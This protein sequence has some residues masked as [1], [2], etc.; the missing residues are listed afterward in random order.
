MSE[1]VSRY[2]QYYREQTPESVVGLFSCMV[3]YDFFSYHDDMKKVYAMWRETRSKGDRSRFCSNGSTTGMPRSLY[4]A[5]NFLL[6]RNS[7]EPF[8]RGKELK[9]MMIAAQ[10]GRP[11]LDPFRHSEVLKNSQKDID[12]V[13]DWLSDKD[14][15]KLFSLVSDM[16]DRYGPI[17]LYALPDIWTCL[18]TNPSFRFLVEENRK[19]VAS[20]VN[21]DYDSIFK[22]IGVHVRDQM[23]D[24]GTG[25]NFFDCEF[26]TRHFL[27]LFFW[28]GLGC[29]N[30]V[31]LVRS[32]PL[33]DDRVVFLG[34]P[35][36]CSCGRPFI[37]TEMQLH[38]RNLI[39]DSFGSSLDLIPLHN[40]LGA[41]YANLQ[42]HQ[43]VGG[44]VKMFY[45]AMSDL[46]DDLEIAEDYFASRGL[47][48]K[49]VRGKYYA[50]GRKRYRA[51]K[52]E[53]VDAQDFILPKRNKDDDSTNRK[54]LFYI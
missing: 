14:I 31:N 28:S 3:D 42:F 51:W 34:G 43:G 10:L 5:P 52:S 38:F 24:W 39:T 35:K 41:H 23:I 12:V 36:M 30:L 45:V 53:S 11:D 54:S 48:I 47:K 25:L 1:L 20:F 13:G 17:N 33:S 44:T 29:L 37:P 40:Q 50:I 46:G 26:G 32:R 16:F 9:T 19:K 27:P 15:K 21:S 18:V 22:R 49:F 8:L 2:K 4:F 6:W 7:L